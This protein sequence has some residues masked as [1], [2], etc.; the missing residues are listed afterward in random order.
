MASSLD[1]ASL[2]ASA[3]KEAPLGFEPFPVPQLVGQSAAIT[4]VKD[5]ASSIARRRSTVMILGESRISKKKRAR[6]IHHT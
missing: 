2:D 1:P 5:I 4:V 3:Q 6:H